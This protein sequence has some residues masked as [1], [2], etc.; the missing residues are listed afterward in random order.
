MNDQE[1]KN[2]ESLIEQNKFDEAK[3]AIKKLFEREISKKEKGEVF[4]SFTLAYI[5]LINSLQERYQE[6]LRGKIK[7]LKKI[8]EAE[9]KND[10]L[11]N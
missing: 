11:I 4:A 8:N 9:K 1:T 2:I 5:S 6:F 3:A 7:E 10:N